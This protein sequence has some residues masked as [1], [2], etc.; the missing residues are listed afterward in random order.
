MLSSRL[1]QRRGDF[2]FLHS[3]RAQHPT[4]RYPARNATAVEELNHD[5]PWPLWLKTFA[6]V[7]VC[8]KVLRIGASVVRGGFGD[9]WNRRSER[10]SFMSVRRLARQA[11]T[12]HLWCIMRLASMSGKLSEDDSIDV[13]FVAGGKQEHA[14][15]YVRTFEHGCSVCTVRATETEVSGMLLRLMLPLLA[16]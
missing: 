15:G 1:P 6:S 5:V 14:C 13:R 16:L 12:L 10:V 8:Y 2:L 7:N 11:L 3:L 4:H 9:Q